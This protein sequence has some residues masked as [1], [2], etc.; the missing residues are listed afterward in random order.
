MSR[1]G[2]NGGRGGRGYSGRESV[3]VHGQGHN[4]SGTNSAPEKGLCTYLGNNVFNY[5]HK[6]A[7]YHIRTS[8]LKLVHHV[9]TK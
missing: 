1:R 2:I 9:G 4:Y 7:A 8:W 3:R 5:V 6:A